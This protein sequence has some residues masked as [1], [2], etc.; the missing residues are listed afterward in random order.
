MKILA[1]LRG[2]TIRCFRETFAR[3]IADF[4][5][6]EAITPFITAAPGYDPLKDRELLNADR[7]SLTT[8]PQFIGKDPAALRY[9]LERIKAAGYETADLNCGCPFPMV[10]NKGRGS[11]LLRTPK[12]L[13][14]M[15]AVGC[16]VMGEGKFSMKTRLGVTEKDELLKLLPLINQFPLRFV[17]V[18][19]RT[20]IQM[21]EGECDLAAYQKVAAECKLPL[22]L[23]G[24]GGEMVGRPFIRALA[25]LLDIR[26][27][28]DKYIENSV[29]ELHAPS[30]V[31]GRLKELIA[32]WKDNPRWSRY[33]RII[34][35][36]R[37]LDELKLALPS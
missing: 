13:A 3:P 26:E 29:A 18:H 6:N 4:G 17:T 34:K 33:W 27:L 12:V 23:N 35:L 37:S 16:E 21:Y 24:P 7:Q 32:Y 20:A 28:L 25:D 14:E 1:P 22:V 30:P 36:A 2:V 8:T 9:C 19:P 5:F 11:G 15:L 10:R 31:V